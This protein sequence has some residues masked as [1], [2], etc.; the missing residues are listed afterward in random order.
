M[1][2]DLISKPDL[3][4]VKRNAVVTDSS[5]KLYL[6]GEYAAVSRDLPKSAVEAQSDANA[7]ATYLHFGTIPVWQFEKVGNLLHALGIV[8]PLT[9]TD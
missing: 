8:G 7:S 3:Q 6:L 9:F 4:L 5:F 2:L 1:D